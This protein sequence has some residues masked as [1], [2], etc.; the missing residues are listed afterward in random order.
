MGGGGARE[1]FVE[2]PYPPDTEGTGMDEGA[3]GG[4][5][6]GRYAE[7]RGGEDEYEYVDAGACVF[8]EYGSL[9]R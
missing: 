5:E 4:P 9:V 6:E 2:V 3:C 8:S 1:K 7:G